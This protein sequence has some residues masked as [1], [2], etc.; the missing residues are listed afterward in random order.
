MSYPQF[1]GGLEHLVDMIRRIPGIVRNFHGTTSG[2]TSTPFWRRG[3][4]SR[5]LESAAQSPDAPYGSTE[6]SFKPNIPPQNPPARTGEN[7]ETL[8]EPLTKIR[9]IF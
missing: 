1:W 3:R 9:Q 5:D 6:R 8:V 2:A 4:L 7:H